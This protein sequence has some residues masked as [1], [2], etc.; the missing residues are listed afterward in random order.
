MSRAETPEPMAEVAA[1]TSV[2]HDKESLIGER[3]SCFLGEKSKW[4]N[5]AAAVRNYI[6]AN[7]EA[8][9][10]DERKIFFVNGLLGSTDNSPSLALTWKC[11]WA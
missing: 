2:H 4:D 6:A 10:C 9:C 11:N 5:F 3:P 7:P 1:P 8:F